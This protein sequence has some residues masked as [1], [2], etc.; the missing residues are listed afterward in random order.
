MTAQQNN[1]PIL[2][3]IKLRSSEFAIYFFGNLEH[4]VKFHSLLA[5]P[6]R[7]AIIIQKLCS[8][9]SIKSYISLKWSGG[10]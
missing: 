2:K 4:G 7:R 5:L 1:T 6:R 8:H 3:A 9:H 10:V